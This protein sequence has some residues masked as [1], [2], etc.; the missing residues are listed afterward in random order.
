MDIRHGSQLC[1]PILGRLHFLIKGKV[2]I[3]DQQTFLP[4]GSQVTGSIPLIHVGTHLAP[5]HRGRPTKRP[6]AL[7][8]T[9]ALPPPMQ[10]G[11][12]CVRRNLQYDF[13]GIEV[14]RK[15]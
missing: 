2:T 10:P 5:K 15:R 7:M 3:I 11:R 6:C 4:N 14:I 9:F 13:F 8:G 1:R 12:S